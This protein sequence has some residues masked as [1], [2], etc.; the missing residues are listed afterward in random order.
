MNILSERS[1]RHVVLAY[2]FTNFA[3]YWETLL[4][5]HLKN[6]VKIIPIIV[7]ISL[8]PACG[9]GVHQGATATNLPQSSPRQMTV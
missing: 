5:A 4:S 1:F 6:L 7:L 2:C 3:K 8:M 9:G